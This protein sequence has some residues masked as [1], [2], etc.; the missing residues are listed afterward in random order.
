LFQT[1]GNSPLGC[2]NDLIPGKVRGLN[3]SPS[4]YIIKKSF[5]ACNIAAVLSQADFIGDAGY[6]GNGQG[7]K[8]TQLQVYLFAFPDPFPAD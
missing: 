5:C 7:Q 8:I 6:C 1:G 2:G 3:F 4:Q